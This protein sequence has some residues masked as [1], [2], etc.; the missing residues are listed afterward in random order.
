MCDVATALTVGSTLIGAYGQYQQGQ[1]ASAMADY[2]ASVQNRMARDALTRGGIAEDNQRMKVRGMIGAQRARTAASGLLVDSGSAGELTDETAM[3]GEM[4]AQTIRANA[5]REAW[6]HK[7]NAVNYQNQGAAASQAGTIG[8][9]T[10]LLTGAVSVG[11]KYGW[12]TPA[13]PAAAPGADYG[14]SKMK[15]WW[16]S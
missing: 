2:N 10:T 12:F 4:D 1:T 8:A 11:D 9:A 16:E 3:F 13:K 6:G 7:V 15:N 5:M 14:S